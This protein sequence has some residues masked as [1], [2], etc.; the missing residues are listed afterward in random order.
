[1]SRDRHTRFVVTEIELDIILEALWEFKRQQDYLRTA[2]APGVDKLRRRLLRD[3]IVSANAQ[4]AVW[5]MA[6]LPPEST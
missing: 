1:M 3:S 5:S 6:A 4:D 2:A